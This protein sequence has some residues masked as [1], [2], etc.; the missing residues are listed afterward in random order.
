MFKLKKQI[1]NQD[2]CENHRA[3]QGSITF[4]YFG[5]RSLSLKNGK[6]K[7]SCARDS[8]TSDEKRWFQN[9]STYSPLKQK[10]CGC[11]TSLR[12]QVSITSQQM[13]KLIKHDCSLSSIKGLSFNN[14][15]INKGNATVRN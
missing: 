15:K 9:E 11:D 13:L 8:K 10:M 14:L 7:L 12:M 1:N 4:N 3:T 6:L 5:W 2:G